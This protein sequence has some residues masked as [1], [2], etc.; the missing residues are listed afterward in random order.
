MQQ[1]VRFGLA[2]D[3]GYQVE[4]R[5]TIRDSRTNGGGARVIS[6]FR[7]R[8]A[9]LAA[10]VCGAVLVAG[11]GESGSGGPVTL[12]WFVATQP[13]GSIEK[14]A[15][16]CSAASNGRYQIEVQLL[17][18]DASQQREQLVRRL[19]AKDSTVDLIGMDVIWTG[20][21]ANAGWISPFPEAEANEVT[22]DV[23][24]SV[25]ETASFENKVYGAPFNSNTQLLWYRKDLVK[26]PPETWDQMI[27]EADRLAS[28]GKPSYIQVQANKYEGFTVWFNALVESAGGRIL[29][30]PTTVSLPEQPTEEALKVMG[31][32]AASA[33][34][35]PNISTS[36]EDTARI[37]FEQGD[38]AFMVNYTFAYASAEANAPSVFKN[39]G[40]ATYPR[41]VANK[42]S[43]P[44]LGGFNIGVGAYSEHQDLAFDAAACI[45][46]DK[47]E[48]TATELDGL[49]PSRED[50]YTNKIVTDAYKG[51][52]PLVKKSIAAAG[53]RPLTPAYQD[54]SL[55]I[56]D[57]LQPPD[58]I[59]PNDVA[60]TYDE[61]KSRVEDAVKGEGLF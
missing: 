60:S 11:C 14:V 48:L 45:G 22:K 50:L 20:E 5:S 13:G 29:S 10:L 38:S 42:P 30:G 4:I 36:D 40:F 1:V 43:K 58:R 3:P 12:N 53:P 37:G 52:A 19:A 27:Q 24:P 28:E 61:L 32:L 23:F 16:D 6:W 34:A 54:V 56:Q 59:D 2:W 49:P 26:K 17:P 15:K 39:M 7:L 46:S 25:K 21:F 51:F 9:C 33:G 31:S 47:S 8:P 35:A 55:A 41:V 18:T 57:T 44:P